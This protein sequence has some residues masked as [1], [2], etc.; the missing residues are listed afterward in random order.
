MDIQVVV[1]QVSGVAGS[2]AAELAAEGLV[3]DIITTINTG[4]APVESTPSTGWVNAALVTEFNNLQTE[5]A[6]L[7]SNVTTYVEENWAYKEDNCREDI[8]YMV[9]AI[10]YDILYGGNSQ[11][12]DAAGEYYSGGVLVLPSTELNPT[13]TT[14]VYLKEITSDII[15]NTAINP[16]QTVSTQSTVNPP[17]TSNEAIKSEELFDI[18]I[19]LLDRGYICEVTLDEN[20]AS[21]NEISI[22]DV[23]AGT[24][25]T[26]HQYSLIVASGHTFEWVGAGININ[27]ALPYEGGRSILANQ[28]VEENGGRIYYT[29]TDQEGDFRIGNDLTINRTTG[30]IEG[31]TFDRSLFAVLTPYILA[32]ED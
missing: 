26:F 12:M 22:N 19:R 5:K 29:S 30:T 9:D 14:Y 6:T 25:I 20:V 15:T 27:S 18:L 3:N 10:T 17:A 31:D 24:E 23:A 7:Q 8:G 11:T 13:I 21:T 2:A 28:V 1:P 32:I 16:L 4:T